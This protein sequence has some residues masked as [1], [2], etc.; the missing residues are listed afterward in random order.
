MAVHPA[1]AATISAAS[2]SSAAVQNAI[3]A[4]SDGDR[5]LVPAGS[6]TWTSPLRV[7]G[8]GVTLAGA[9]IGQTTIVNGTN[10]IALQF[11]LTPGDPTTYVEGFTF[12]ANNSNA[13][14][15]ISLNGGGRNQFRI[16]HFSMI[17]LR[18]RGIIVDMDG[19]AVSGLIDNCSMNMPIT[20]GSKA[21]S[22]SGTGPEESQPFSRPLALGSERLHLCRSLH[23]QLWRPQRRRPGC[24]RRCPLRFPAQHGD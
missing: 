4:A 5:V 17:N 2:C 13:E 21:I 24:L 3:N 10:G 11:D 20:N 9:G 19:L 8:K 14:A 12:D 22:I 16:H 7:S 18:E 23:V 15:M 6:C 1:K